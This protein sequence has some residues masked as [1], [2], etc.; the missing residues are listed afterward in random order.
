VT[1]G[2]NEI[3]GGAGVSQLDGGDETVCELK[4][5][6]LLP[7]IRGLGLGEEML[8]LCLASA[9]EAGYETCYLET[10]REMTT[11]RS[12][13]QKFGFEPLETPMGNTGHFRC[14][15]WFARKL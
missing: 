12:L 2:D 7:E 3:V 15:R 4:K 6:Y 13:Y 11:A 1:N 9:R 10:I 14:D 8:E 5:M